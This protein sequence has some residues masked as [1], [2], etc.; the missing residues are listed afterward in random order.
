MGL[1][2]GTFSIGRN[3]VARASALLYWIFWTR[4]HAARTDLPLLQV[5][6]SRPDRFDKSSLHHAA[7]LPTPPPFAGG[8]RRRHAQPRIG[9]KR[10]RVPHSAGTRLSGVSPWPFP[11]LADVG[12]WLGTRSRL[13]SED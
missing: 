2:F 9:G 10:Q 6:R 11:H 5:D 1:A 7:E 13:K 3:S 12:K 8:A 4:V